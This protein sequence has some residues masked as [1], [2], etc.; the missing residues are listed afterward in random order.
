M[1]IKTRKTHSFIE[2]KVDQHE[3]IIFKEDREEINEM[4]LNLLNVI[5]DL[6]SYTDKSLQECVTDFGF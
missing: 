2:I 6:S 5:E 4:I 3:V 1:K